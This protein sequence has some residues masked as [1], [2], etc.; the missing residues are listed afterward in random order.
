MARPNVEVSASS[1]MDER[2]MNS[3]QSRASGADWSSNLLGDYAE[4]DASRYGASGEG[5]LYGGS[6]EYGDMWENEALLRVLDEAN[7]MAKRQGKKG[8]WDYKGK[9]DNKS[10]EWDWIKRGGS[11][12]FGRAFYQEGNKFYND[13]RLSTEEGR[14]QIWKEA[15]GGV[16]GENAVFTDIGML[17]AQY[18]YTPDQIARFSRELDARRISTGQYD[19]TD[20]DE[21]GRLQKG[22]TSQYTAAS[23]FNALNPDNIDPGNYVTSQEQPETMRA[24]IERL[25]K[26]EQEYRNDPQIAQA[27]RM[28]EQQEDGL[29]R[30]RRV[31][32]G[33][34]KTVAELQRDQM[35]SQARRAVFSQLASSRGGFNPGLQRAALFATAQS[36]ASVAADVAARA[37]AERMQMLGAY[38]SGTSALTDQ[39]ANFAA[40]QSGILQ[41]IEQRRAGTEM[42]GLA[43]NENQAALQ[44]QLDID[45]TNRAIARLN[46]M[47][48]QKED[49]PGPNYLQAGLAGGTALAGAL[50]TFYGGGAVGVPM[51]MSGGAGVY[52]ALTQQGREPTTVMAAGRPTAGTPQM[53][54]AAAMQSAGVK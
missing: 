11:D 9:F 27:R 47:R 7:R 28:L 17:A 23:G 33:D 5:T 40:Q 24:Q 2:Q 12:G 22:P 6:S 18:G 42:A 39:A 20:F 34:E 38:L 41:G 32:Y 54:L 31:A 37:Q 14:A 43:F 52:G 44:R 45:R 49:G 48:D 19:P 3:V 53:D 25:D 4:W 29:Q 35:Q 1:P 21:K 13:P 10:G 46:L 50:A 30:I 8:A 15:F 16:S 36:S 26:I 51:I